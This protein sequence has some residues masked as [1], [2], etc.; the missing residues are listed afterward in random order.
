MKKIAT[1]VA[2]SF[3]FASVSFADD[4]ASHQDQN[5]DVSHH[6]VQHVYTVPSSL[7]QCQK[8]TTKLIRQTVGCY[9]IDDNDQV[10]MH[11]DVKFDYDSAT[12]TT[13]GKQAVSNLV[14]FMK[15]NGVDHV[16][17]R[18][19]A[20]QGVP[21][22]PF[23]SYNEKLSYKRGLSIKA[24]MIQKG[25]D[26]D[27]ISIKAFGWND[28][29]VPNDSRDNRRINQRVEAQVMAPLADTKETDKAGDRDE[30][31]RSVYQLP[32]DV[33]ECTSETTE[34]TRQSVGCYTVEGNKVYMHVD[35]KYPY[36]SAELTDESK[37][38]VDKLV[39]F[40]KQYDVDSATIRGY[41][42]KGVP[43]QPFKNY[44]E[45]LSAKRAESV[46]NYLD[47]DGIDTQNIKIKGLGWK[48][49]LVPNSSRENRQINQRIETTIEAPLKGDAPEKADQE[50]QSKDDTKAEQKKKRTKAK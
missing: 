24:Y 44:N 1:L 39:S 23:K 14:Q 48:D 32:K 37:Q 6:F 28:P 49:P 3:C 50:K 45:K 5:Y 16:N 38:A 34:A 40:M 18:G 31:V 19:Y 13:Q 46:K 9:T 7:E 43:G 22:E 33:S 42:S 27:S 17:I 11:L 29:L 15:E 20:S 35:A 25:V 21:G 47:T 36:D 26:A 2:A 41:A 4:H 30:V 12:L 8:D 10:E